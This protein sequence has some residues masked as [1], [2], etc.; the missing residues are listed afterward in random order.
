ME[1]A[2][3]LFEAKGGIEAYKDEIAQLQQA[4]IE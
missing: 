4:M 3:A 2:N 1:M